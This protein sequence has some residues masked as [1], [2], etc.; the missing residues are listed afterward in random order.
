M[1]QNHEQKKEDYTGF[2]E[3]EFT[4]SLYDNKRSMN[5]LILT[6]NDLLEEIK[7]QVAELEPNK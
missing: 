4:R 3:H 5:D 2:E 6:I 7:Y 1:R